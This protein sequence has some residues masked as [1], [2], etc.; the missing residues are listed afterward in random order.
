[1]KKT[2][3]VFCVLLS[4]LFVVFP[5]SACVENRDSIKETEDASVNPVVAVAWSNTPDSYSYTS[6]VSA[7]EE[8]GGTAVVLDMVQSYDL[9]YND[10]GQ[11]TE[12]KDSHG[13]LTKDAAKL[14]KCNTW[15]DSNVESVMEGVTSIIFPGGIDISPTLYYDEQDWHGIKE[16]TEYSAERDVSDYLLLS[17]CLEENIPILAI[18]RG[19]QMLTVVSGGDIIQ[20]LP[21]WFKEQNVKYTLQHR[22]PEKKDLI[23]HQVNVLS[24]DSLLYSITGKETLEGCPSWHH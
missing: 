2:K 3:N 21:T 20:D 11:L 7:I 18:C 16:D 8:A 13:I 10:D 6:T 5:L 23:P 14:V 12:G 17:Y 4:V 19:M 24:K 22:D 1:M 15:Q 9:V